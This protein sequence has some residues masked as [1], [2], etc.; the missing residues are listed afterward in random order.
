MNKQLDPVE[1]DAIRK[2]LEQARRGEGEPA[3]RVLARLR[4]KHR[5]P[6]AK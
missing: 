1:L 5:L 2:G 4:K 6:K 3:R